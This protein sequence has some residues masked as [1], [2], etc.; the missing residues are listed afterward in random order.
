MSKIL[1]LLSAAALLLSMAFAPDAFSASLQQVGSFEQTIYVSSDPGNPERLFVVERQG[2]IALDREG[3]VSTFADLRSVVS[4]CEG[5][6]GLLSVAPAPDF[7]T[8]GRLYVDYVGTEKTGE[9]GEPEIHVAELRAVGNEAAFS[10][11]RNVLT[12]PHPGQSNHYGGQLQFGPDGYLYIST[13]DGGGSNDVMHN[14]Q[15]PESLLGKIL[16]IDPRP[17][18]IQPYV[19][20][21]SN[22]FPLAAAPANTIWSL[23]LRNPFRFSFDRLDG[24]LAIGDVGQ[25][26][27]EEVDLAAGPGFGAGA[28]FGWNCREGSIAGPADDPQCATPPPGGFVEPVFDYP[29]TDPGGGAAH[30]CAIIGGYVERDPSVTD[31]YGRYVY[32]DLCTGEIRSFAP[33]NPYA[34]D[35][36][37]GLELPNLNSFGEDSCGRLYAVAGDGSVDRIVGQSPATCSITYRSSSSRRPSFVGLRA[38]H[39]KVERNRKVQITAW[40][41][42]CQARTGERVR[43]LRAGDH[44][45]TK[46]LSVACTAEFLAR[47]SHPVT[48]RA[49]VG[50][51]ATYEAS[52]SKPVR[53]RVERR[54]H[55]SH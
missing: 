2:R 9:P 33:S 12:I 27:R 44:I 15:N 32:G 37:T 5:E 50:E 38:A 25:D 6:R 23:G 1:G 35:H 7:D 13:G 16:R 22:P 48:F 43:L 42:P 18:G 30:G 46:R 51:D 10:T 36:S 19:V 20:P 54:H 34:S 52:F 53:V 47:V 55:R 39:R 14:S 11:L 21:P 31:L 17:N 41:S 28:N 24:T 40:V 26:A 29:H 49:V 3:V 8:S 4:C 45:A